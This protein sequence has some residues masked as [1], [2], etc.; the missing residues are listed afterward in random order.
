M[1]SRRKLFGGIAAAGLAGCAPDGGGAGE[2]T[3]PITVGLTYIPNVQ[4]CAFY[5]GVEEG[6]FGDVD[7]K[8]RHHGEQEDLFGA[9]LSDEEQVVFASSDEAVV[10]NKGIVTVATA[11]QEYPVEIVF[12]EPAESLADLKGRTLGIPGRFGSSYYAALVALKEAGLTE[13]DVEIQE[14]GFTLVPALAT[15]KV[16]AITGFANNDVVQL[17]SLGKEI[18]RVPISKEPMLVGPG[19]MTTEK[20]E[21]DPRV[22]AVVEGM[23]AAEKRAV[24]D[25]E[26]ALAATKKQV[27]A[28]A[29]EE[30]LA[31]A[32]EVL[33]ATSELWRNSNGEISVDVDKS[34]MQRMEKFLDEAGLIGGQE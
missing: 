11:Y 13:D 24:E 33:K 8:I 4:F 12:R 21:E 30:Q 25:P 22:K 14:I 5:L 16:D 28:L 19:L 31:T 7:V 29:D 26:A 18:W 32:R 9:L 15:D 17:K 10:A 6:L 20:L 34:A 2:A 27:P 3:G 23:L 1:I